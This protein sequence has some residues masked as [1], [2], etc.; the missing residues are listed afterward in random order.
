MFSI[1]ATVKPFK[2][3]DVREALADLGVGGMTVTEILRQVVAQKTSRRFSDSEMALGDLTPHVQ[4]R[5]V[6]SDWLVEP[7][8]E[9]LCIHGPSGKLDDSLITVSRVE[10]VV[11]IRTGDKNDD[12]LST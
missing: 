11:R 3:D 10:S 7:V 2:L 8:I 1:E 5:V 12:A 6:V 4:V 9:A